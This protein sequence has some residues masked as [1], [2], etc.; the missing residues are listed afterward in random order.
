VLKLWHST[1]IGAHRLCLA[2]NHS[3]RLPLFT[4][5]SDSQD[6]S[7]HHCHNITIDQWTLIRDYHH[8]HSGMMCAVCLTTGLRCHLSLSH[9]TVSAPSA[10][11]AAKPKCMRAYTDLSCIEA[12]QSCRLQ[13]FHSIDFPGRRWIVAF[14]F[15]D[16]VASISGRRITSA[17]SGD[18]K[19]IVLALSF[20]K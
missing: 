1:T 10:A 9:L 4:I 17:G 8:L 14:F 6:H 18:G 19:C 12:H 5:E 11:H 15:S 2:R 13:S 16:L 20:L 3:S 7:H